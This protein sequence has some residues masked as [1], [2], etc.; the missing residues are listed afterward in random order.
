MTTVFD[1]TTVHEE[2][3]M[4]HG[5]TTDPT[6][7]THKQRAVLALLAQGLTFR[8][9]G[10]ALGISEDTAKHRANMA[11][12]ALGTQNAVHTVAEAIR[13]GLLPKDTK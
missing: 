5:H 13:R 6:P 10:E 9:V 1:P 11:R 7:L 3:R 2:Y 12:R 4:N 8:K